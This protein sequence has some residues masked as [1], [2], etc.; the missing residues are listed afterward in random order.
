M[1]EY[2][3]WMQGPVPHLVA[4]KELLRAKRKIGMIKVKSNSGRRFLGN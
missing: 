2:C 1:V 3:L 4:C